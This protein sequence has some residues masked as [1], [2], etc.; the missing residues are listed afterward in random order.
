MNL[1]ELSSIQGLIRNQRRLSG[2]A[3]SKLLDWELRGKVLTLLKVFHRNLIIKV[4]MTDQILVPAAS[5]SLLQATSLQAFTKTLNV[6]T[7]DN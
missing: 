3:N 1:M 6:V 4:C 7:R 5:T 2:S